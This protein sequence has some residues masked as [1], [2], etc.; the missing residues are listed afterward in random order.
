MDAAKRYR[1]DSKKLQKN[2]GNGTRRKTR[3]ENKQAEDSQD[4]GLNP[5]IF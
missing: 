1:V 5:S 3:K 2:R 4:A